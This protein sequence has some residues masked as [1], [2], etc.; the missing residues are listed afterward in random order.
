[1]KKL[2]VF[3]FAVFS[4]FLLTNCINIETD[5][6]KE[7]KEEKQKENL[8]DEIDKDLDE[9]KE[10]LKDAFGNLE[11]AF[12]GLKKKHNVG[13]KEPINFR[14]MKKALPRSLA[15]VRRPRS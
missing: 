1:M 13:E 12:E 2:F 3:A 5:E 7:R 11:D 9:A 14:D 4:A 8:Q 10:D 15:G 6:Q